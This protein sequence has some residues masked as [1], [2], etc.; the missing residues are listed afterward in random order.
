V[1]VSKACSVTAHTVCRTPPRQRQQRGFEVDVLFDERTGV[2]FGRE[3]FG[4][5]RFYDAHAVEQ[6]RQIA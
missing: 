3:R 4:E 5:L 6:L 2:R 1:S